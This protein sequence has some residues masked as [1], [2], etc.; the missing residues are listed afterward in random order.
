MIYTQYSYG[1]Q[2]L[3]SGYPHIAGLNPQHISGMAGIARGCACLNYEEPHPNLA[4]ELTTPKQLGSSTAKRI[5]DEIAKWDSENRRLSLAL[6]GY[7]PDRRLVA[8]THWPILPGVQYGANPDLWLAGNRRLAKRAFEFVDAIGVHAYI[9]S[10]DKAT[11]V[12]GAVDYATKRLDHCL[13]T[14][15]AGK[16]LVLYLCQ[17]YIGT[18]EMVPDELLAAQ[19]RVAIER[20]VDVCFWLPMHPSE[21]SRWSE[22]VRRVETLTKVVQ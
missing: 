20:G 16:A 12:A 11:T 21:L 13:S 1:G 17:T 5:T 6:R 4:P 10:D 3:D 14:R 9:H 2:Q 22:Q 7:A 15:P 18:R 19:T 8:Y